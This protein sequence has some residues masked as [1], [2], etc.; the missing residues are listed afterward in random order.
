MRSAIKAIFFWLTTPFNQ[1][2]HFWSGTP[3]SHKTETPGVKEEK[4]KKK[5]NPR[6]H[7]K[8]FPAKLHPIN[9]LTKTPDKPLH[10]TCFQGIILPLY[11]RISPNLFS[12]SDIILYC[13][14]LF[15]GHSRLLSA[16]LLL[17]AKRDILA[18]CLQWFFCC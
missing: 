15:P 14:C 16:V 13:S 7:S 6:S 8:T 10:D 1:P 17:L 3:S 18:C 11:H 2:H 4:K 9:P 12:S 5:I